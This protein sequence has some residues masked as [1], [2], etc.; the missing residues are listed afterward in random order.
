LDTAD[1]TRAEAPVRLSR[2]CRCQRGLVALGYAIGGN[3]S[4]TTA[5]ILARMGSSACREAAL[6]NVRRMA[7]CPPIKMPDYCSVKRGFGSL[8]ERKSGL[9]LVKAGI[10]VEGCFE[11]GTAMRLLCE[12]WAPLFVF[13][14]HLLSFCFGWCIG[15]FVLA[16]WSCSCPA[17]PGALFSCRRSYDGEGGFLSSRKYLKSRVLLHLYVLF[18]FEHVP[19][20]R[21]S[22]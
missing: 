19:Q 10:W 1:R 4:T 13:T 7:K 3:H 16:G 5:A 8:M 22:T 12:V 20:R 21:L 2:I 17:F 9:P 15:I 14:A 11:P 6:F 18:S